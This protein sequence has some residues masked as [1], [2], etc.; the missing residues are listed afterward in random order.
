MRYKIPFVYFG[1]WAERAKKA[2]LSPLFDGVLQI[3]CFENETGNRNQ[4]R[5]IFLMRWKILYKNIKNKNNMDNK[6]SSV[7]GILLNATGA[8]FRAK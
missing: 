2:Q 5:V 1:L 6:F 4:H 8:L 3:E 7:P